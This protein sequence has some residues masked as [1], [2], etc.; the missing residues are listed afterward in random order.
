MFKRLFITVVFLGMVCGVCAAQDAKNPF[1]AQK[2]RVAKVIAKKPMQLAIIPPV[3]DAKSTNPLINVGAQLGLE[4][5]KLTP[6]QM[7]DPNVFNP[8]KYPVIIYNAVEKVARDYKGKDLIEALKTYM[9]SGGVLVSTGACWPFYYRCD[10]DGA[11]FAERDPN[12]VSA[13][14]GVFMASRWE[15]PPEGLTVVLKHSPDDKI[16][17]SLPKEIPYPVKGDIRLRSFDAPMADA[18]GGNYKPV[19]SVEDSDG[20][21]NGEVIAVYERPADFKKSTIIFIWGTLMATQYA[22]GIV[23]DA[24][25]YAVEKAGK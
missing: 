16:F 10:W 12:P 5:I 2:D 20:G 19:L 8:Q 14:I 7:A 9:S 4:V 23:A 13:E 15:K 24:F 21:T 22:D 1:Q 25:A 6:E 17:G 3:G 11:K 18:E